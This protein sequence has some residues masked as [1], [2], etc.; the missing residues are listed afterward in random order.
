MDGVLTDSEHLYEFAFVKVLK[1]YG[2]PRE[3]V[4][5]SSFHGHDAINLARQICKEYKL[6]ASPAHL[7]DEVNIALRSIDAPPLYQGV[8]EVLSLTEGYP[9]AVVTNSSREACEYFL[10]VNGIRDKFQGIVT[11][12]DVSAP[13]PSP[14]SY[15]KGAE[16]IGL[17]ASQCLALE[18]SF[19]GLQAA[20][21]S[22]ATVYALSTSYTADEIRRGFPSIGDNI[23]SSIEEAVKEALQRFFVE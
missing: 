17:P 4:K 12:D 23:F 16:L 3:G 9:R 2:V 18:D 10:K 5:F 8:P 22:N 19:P 20:S 21:S 6:S 11:H 1:A 7:I 15:L 13:K 14:E